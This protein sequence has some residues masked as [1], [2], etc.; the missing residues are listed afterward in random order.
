MKKVKRQM[1]G[2]PIVTQWKQ[3]WLGTMRLWIRSLASLS[4]LRILCYHELWCKCRLSS[5]PAL[6]WLWHRPAAAAPIRP[7]AW[8]PPC[9]TG[10][11][12][13]TKIKTKTKTNDK[14]G[15][16]IYYIYNKGY[17]LFAKISNNS[18]RKRQSSFF[19][20]T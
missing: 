20:E 8:E 18:I 13:K 7:L 14:H 12:L 5:D 9:A 19:K 2:V 10:A 16:D 15:E 6:L 4:E 3:I 11:A 17:I 1:T